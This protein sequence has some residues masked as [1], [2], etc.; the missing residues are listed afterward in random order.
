MGR[1]RLRDAVSAAVWRRVYR[2]R[3]LRPLMPQWRVVVEAAPER[4][5]GVWP[6][7]VEGA[8]I[9]V[10]VWACSVEEAEGVAQLAVL[11]QGLVPLTADAVAI[12][13][14]AAPKREAGVARVA[15]A[16]F[17]GP[18]GD[19]SASLVRMGRRQPPG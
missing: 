2:W 8:V 15:S 7:E 4:S 1:A 6:A 10:V 11:E 13:P 14:E 3:L 18:L 5:G 12:A 9:G 19:A 16:C 17:Y